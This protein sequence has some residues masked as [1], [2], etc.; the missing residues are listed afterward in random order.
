MV[1]VGLR[2][3]GVREELQSPGCTG[4]YQVWQREG[5]CWGREDPALDLPLPAMLRGLRGP[6]GGL[7]VSSR[8]ADTCCVLEL[9][10]CS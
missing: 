8:G 3:L 4:G 6:G 1:S 5:T 2:S 9:W 10:P 7:L